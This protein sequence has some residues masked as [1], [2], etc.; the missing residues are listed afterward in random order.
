[1]VAAIAA[2]VVLGA[3]SLAVAHPLG[4]DAWSWMVWARELLHGDVHTAGG[5][6]IKALP[7]IVMAPFT[8]LGGAAPLLWLALMR[9]SALVAVLL[10]YRVGERL[11]GWIAG[12][13]A[14]GLLVVGPDL[15]RTALYGSAE[16]LLLVF[17]L[18][19]AERF[20]AGRPRAAL[21]LLGAG[22][23]IRPELWPFVGVLA[24]LVCVERRRPD[25][26]VLA[27]AIV[28]PVIWLALV[29]AGSGN[30]F[31]QW[32]SINA[33][34]G[35]VRGLLP[36]AAAHGPAVE[37]LVRL[38]E[39]IVLPALVLAAVAVVD[40]VRHRRMQVAWIAAVAIAWILL[41]AVMA[42]AG[43]PGSRRY[44]LGP[45]SLLAV[46]AGA[47]L[48][49]VVASVRGAAAR[50]ALGAAL[51][52]VILLA[53]FPTIRESA[54]LVGVARAQDR[55]LSGLRHAIALAG[56]RRSVLAAGRPAVNPWMQT[57]LAW[58]LHARLA[59]VQA[60]WGSHAAAPNWYPPAVVFRGPARFA[61]ARPAVP[62]RR[63]AVRIARTGSWQVLR[64]S[65]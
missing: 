60:T 61:G 41:V 32:I 26:V 47:G 2:A 36:V 28:P 43:Y 15:Y 4:Y 40:A 53:A 12:L 45:A 51:G 34:A 13:T 1:V 5:P 59:D 30:P 54:R 10:A 46:L 58:E 63:H 9:I 33:T 39:A 7:V 44:L 35:P 48:A 52:G 21:V 27:A 24:L 19:A 42:Q 65:G 29:W 55:T 8:P 18:A 50:I 17:V 23:L 6:A 38:A 3:A 25:P 56:G 64:V 57:A 16:P 31:A 49:L 11:G 37:V 14:A 22:G 20:L 62:A